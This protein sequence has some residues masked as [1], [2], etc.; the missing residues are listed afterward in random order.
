MKGEQQHAQGNHGP[1]TRQRIAEEA[2]EPSPDRMKAVVHE[3]P[4][5]ER[6]DAGE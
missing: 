1:V 5:D 2:H 3:E 6:P 4:R